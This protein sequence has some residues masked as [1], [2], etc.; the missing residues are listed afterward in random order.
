LKTPIQNE[1]VIA[2]HTLLV[3]A[4]IHSMLDDRGDVVI[5][6]I[7]GITVNGMLPGPRLARRVEDLLTGD[8]DIYEELCMRQPTVDQVMLEL[9]ERKYD[10]ERES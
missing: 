6:E 10:G 4:T 5:T 8:G 9:A 2:G 1:M 3:S 7:T